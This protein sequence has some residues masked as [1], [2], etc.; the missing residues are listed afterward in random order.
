[1]QISIRAESKKV[2]DSIRI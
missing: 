2:K 1:V